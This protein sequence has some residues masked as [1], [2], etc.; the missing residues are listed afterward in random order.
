MMKTWWRPA[1]IESGQSF[2]CFMKQIKTKLFCTCL[3][4]V[5]VMKVNRLKWAEE[6]TSYDKWRN[7]WTHE[8]VCKLQIKSIFCLHDVKQPLPPCFF[9]LSHLLL[10]TPLT[11]RHNLWHTPRHKKSWICLIFICCLSSVL[12]ALWLWNECWVNS[13]IYTWEQQI[14]TRSNDR[15][16]VKWNLSA[17]FRSVHMQFDLVAIKKK[18]SWVSHFQYLTKLSVRNIV[19]EVTVKPLE[20]WGFSPFYS[21]K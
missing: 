12:W 20:S 19:V 10:F 5:F 7:A 11:A 2:K 13:T 4:N 9:E 8:C 21:I 16:S 17:A 15:H 18:L 14:F 1:E 6:I 3:K